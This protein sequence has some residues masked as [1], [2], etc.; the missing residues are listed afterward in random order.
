MS[1]EFI[2]LAIQK[3]DA[4]GAIWMEA[5]PGANHGTV[6]VKPAKVGHRVPVGKIIV[7]E[8][9]AIF[10]KQEDIEKGVF[11]KDFAFT[12]NN[13]VFWHCHELVYHTKWGNFHITRDKV[14]DCL[15]CDKCYMSVHD[16]GTVD[17][18]IIIP[19]NE[20]SVVAKSP[21]EQELID[22][23]GAGWYWIFRKIL[24]TKPFYREMRDAKKRGERIDFS[25][26]SV[27]KEIEPKMVR[28]LRVSGAGAR[29]WRWDELSK[30]LY[31]SADIGASYVFGDCV[32]RVVSLIR[33]YRGAHVLVAD[34][35]RDLIEA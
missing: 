16:R 28:K 19:L 22:I 9:K 6:Y 17:G 13:Y 8:G 31:L 34:A 3:T 25:P 4:S 23:M 14:K 5:N 33:S 27:F 11:R 15:A 35:A 30:T 20:W 21:F 12:M 18:K 29:K 7:G 1:I 24:R 32:E 2:Q 26:F 10:H